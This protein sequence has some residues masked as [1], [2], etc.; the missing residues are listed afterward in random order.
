VLI[1]VVALKEGLGAARLV[2]AGASLLNRD[3][4]AEG[5]GFHT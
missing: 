1:K 2:E 5:C 4:G 3:D